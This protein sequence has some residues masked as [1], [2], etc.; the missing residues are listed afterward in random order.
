MHFNLELAVVK[1]LAALRASLW[2]DIGLRLEADVSVVVMMR[3]S[4]EKEKLRSD[5]QDQL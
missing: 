5:A 4:F 1:Y 3:E 2:C